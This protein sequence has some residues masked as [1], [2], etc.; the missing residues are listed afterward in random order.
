[1]GTLLSITG[2]AWQGSSQDLNLWF[3]FSFFFLPSKTLNIHNIRFDDGE[4][5]IMW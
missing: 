3:F 2:R 4:F 5:L 1:M